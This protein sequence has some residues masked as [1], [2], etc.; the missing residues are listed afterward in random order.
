M[1]L[2][3]DKAGATEATKQLLLSIG[4]NVDTDHLRDTPNRVAKAWQEWTKGYHENPEDILKTF[5]NDN[6]GKSSNRWIIV[7]K[8]PIVS[9][10]C[11]HL[12]PIRGVA[13]IGYVP[14]NKLVGLSKLSRVASVYMR[15][16]QI[17][18]ALTC[19][20]V[21]CLEAVLQPL[22]VGVYITAGHGCMDSRGV[23]IHGT[24]TST[25]EFRF[26]HEV[27]PEDVRYYE[28]DFFQM[29]Q[30]NDK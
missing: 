21:D 11:H 30:L 25:S 12:A 2:K 15:R 3:Y 7:H 20:I 18:E 28:E 10:C 13:H 17:Q 22:A 26:A 6:F 23:N 1:V 27:L 16:L 29:V 4:V 5:P 24:T 8:I 14:R 9:T 19:E